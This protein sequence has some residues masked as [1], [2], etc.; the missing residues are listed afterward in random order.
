MTLLSISMAAMTC[1]DDLGHGIENRYA[2]EGGPAL[3]RGDSRHHQRPVF[4]TGMGM[5]LPGGTCDPLGQNT[6]VFVNQYRHF[7]KSGNRHE[8]T[9]NSFFL[10]PHAS[11]LL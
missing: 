5:E 2:L 11:R 7:L 9:G 3:S 4:F 1:R 10:T 6:R 8:A